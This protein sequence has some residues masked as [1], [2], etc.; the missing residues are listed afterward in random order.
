MSYEKTIINCNLQLICKQCWLCI[1]VANTIR[2]NFDAT[3]NSDNNDSHV[4]NIKIFKIQN[5]GRS[6]LE[7]YSKCH[8]SPANGPTGMQLV[9]SHPIMFLILEM[10]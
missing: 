2:N 5:G 1:Y 8:N 4:I 6:L 10:L 7:K 3:A 9:W